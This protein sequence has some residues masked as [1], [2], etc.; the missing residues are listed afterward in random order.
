MFAPRGMIGRDAL[1]RWSLHSAHSPYAAASPFYSAAL[2]CAKQG[3]PAAAIWLWTAPLPPPR[4]SARRGC[5]FSSV[6]RAHHS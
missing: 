6:G 4:P 1:A 2:A 5:R 3:L